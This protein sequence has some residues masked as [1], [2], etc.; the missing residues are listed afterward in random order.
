MITTAG[1]RRAR[2]F[3][4]FFPRFIT[5]GLFDVWPFLWVFFQKRQTIKVDIQVVGNNVTI[6]Q[7]PDDTPTE[8]S[9][10]G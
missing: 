7:V 4:P 10:E 6:Q 1:F 5:M 8:N 9:N 2:W 3:T